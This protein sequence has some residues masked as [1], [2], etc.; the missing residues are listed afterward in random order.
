MA[1]CHDV[2]KTRA[3]N[4]YYGM[5]LT[6]EPKRSCLYAIYAFMRA[7]DDLADGEDLTEPLPP[8]ET[9]QQ[10]EGF[11][12]RMDAVL[13]GSEPPAEEPFW[14]AF[15]HVCEQFPIERPHL[16]AML[17]G[18]IADLF[19]NRYA[20]FDELYKYCYNVAS[21]VGLV[22]V[23]VWGYDNDRSTLQ[24][25]EYRGIALQLTNILRDLSEDAQRGR[26]YLPQEDLERFGYTEN[27][28][29]AGKANEAFDRMMTFQIERAR[30]YYEMSETLERKI[31]ADSRGAC[32]AMMRIYRGLLDRIAANPR[33]VFRKRVRLGG[34]Q[35][36]SIALAATWKRAWT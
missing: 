1:H 28:L 24:L 6:P 16:H 29:I 31:N 17:D 3:R 26:I 21:V 34:V 22:C 10:I 7:C 33:Q 9:Q 32:W 13:D 4:F 30:S 36:A 2:A 15:K 11:R 27:D 18:Q 8:L 14:L 12:R 25:A 19:K 20:S 23:A 5:K 35:K